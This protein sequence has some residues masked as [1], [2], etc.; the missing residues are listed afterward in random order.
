M[1]KL[2]YFLSSTLL[3][4][5]FT[6]MGPNTMGQTPSITVIQPNGGEQWVVGTSH[7]IS[8]TDNL[9]QPVMIVLTTNGVNDTLTHSVSGTTWTWDIPSTQDTS[10][11]C[12][13]KIVSTVDNSVSATSDAFF[14]L[15]GSQ[16][17]DSNEF[18]Q[19]NGGEAW[20]AG[21]SH[22]V[23][24]TN[25]VANSTLKLSIDNGATYTTLPGAD[26]ITGSTFTWDIPSSQT[27]SGTCLLK[28]QS[29]SDTNVY[30]L[31]DSLFSIVSTP[32]SGEISLFQPS[33]AGIHWKQGTEHLISWSDNFDAP[34]KIELLRSGNLY[35][36][37]S[38]S[39]TG[40]GY[41]WTVSDTLPADTSYKVV[42]LNTLNSAISDTSNYSFTIDT[43]TA[44]DTTAVAD[45][46][47]L[48]QPNG[49]DFWAVGTEHLIS[50]YDNFNSPVKIELMKAD[51]VYSVLAASVSGNGF[52]WEIADSIPVGSDFKIK[53]TSTADTAVHDVS[54][55]AFSILATPSGGVISLIQPD[56]AENWVLG[57]EHLISWSDNFTNP[58]TVELY[59]TDTLYSVLATGITD[60]RYAWTIAD[61]IPEG[62]DFMIKVFNEADTTIR[63]SSSVNFSIIAIPPNGEIK[64]AQPNGDE[65]W[66]MNH[67][68]LISW[69][70]NFSYPV[71]VDL[72]HT[73]TLYTVLNASVTGNSYTWS[74]PDTIPPDTT[75]RVRV[76][77]TADTSVWD[78]SD[79]TFTILTHLAQSINLV[80]PNGGETWAVGTKHLLSWYS[81]F[82]DPVKV[83][84]YHDDTLYAVLDSNNTDNRY[85]WNIS[86]TTLVDTGYKVKIFSMVDTTVA[87]VSDSSFSVVEFVPGGTIKLVQPND[88]AIQW[89]RGN[90]YIISWTD[91]L[92]EPVDITLLDSTASGYVA[93]PIA[94]DVPGST[95]S[96]EIP[97][98]VDLGDQ[99]KIV[100]ASSLQPIS[101]TSNNFFSIVQFQPGGTIHLVQPSDT[102]IEWTPDTKHLISWTD[103]LKEPIDIVLLREAN[104]TLDTLAKD[105]EGSTYTWHIPD[106]ISLGSYK[107]IVSSSLQAIDDTSENSFSI[108]PYVPG[109]TVHVIQP[110]VEGIYWARGTEHL[111][112]WTDN[113]KEPVNI[114]LT[115]GTDTT[116][117][118]SNVEGSTYSWDISDTTP[119]AANYRIIVASSAQPV[120]D[121]SDSTFSI[122]A[123]VPGGMIQ[124]MQP[125]RGEKWALG[126]AHLISWT[127]NLSESVNI[128]LIDT[129][130]A[131]TS[132][133]AGNVEGSTYAWTIPNTLTAGSQYKIKV[134]SSLQPISDVSDSTFSL[135]TYEPG[136]EVTVVQPNGK[137]QWTKGNAYLISWTRNFAYP[138]KVELLKADTVYS[139]LDASVDGNSMTWNIPNTLPVDN[140]YSIKVINTV[141][142]SVW[143]QSDT[144]FSIVAYTPGGFITLE[145][146]NGG[147][148]WKLGSQHLISWTNNFTEPVNVEL[149]DSVASPVYRVTIGSNVMGN[150]FTW[151]VEDTLPTSNNYRILVSNSANSAIYDESDG[152]FSLIAP[153]KISVYPNPSTNFINITLPDKGDMNYV[154]NVYNRYGTRVY[155]SVLNSINSQDLRLPT[156]N[157]PNGIY[158]VTL[159]SST[160]RTSQMFIVQH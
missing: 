59:K 104:T 144:T 150:S 99:Y 86:D 61:S 73:D 128:Y 145:Q 52:G 69:S 8:W 153:S 5:L 132:L 124:V 114:S 11:Q 91:N 127:D 76:T 131:D 32:S 142:T 15:K 49:G 25:Y 74:V 40:S 62:H 47:V 101:D 138:L 152:D 94:T 133:I 13:I 1:K 48:V 81:N 2:Y 16:P 92:G 115:D 55:S 67:D 129:V 20:A 17:A 30:I 146:P 28:L 26:S 135:T 136:G 113:L 42:V 96:W 50:W 139:V 6:M 51:T 66:A 151:T 108:V 158:F 117:L 154:V 39:E 21:T 41:A 56:S 122:V 57:T 87:D 46:I 109:G 160:E 75:Y 143:D 22:L 34:V 112:S 82:D 79:T 121:E 97:N 85:T 147:E 159:T 54:D 12:K 38:A 31:S 18:I 3:A 140:D 37:L 33:D 36:T 126:T 98:T 155:T 149:I 89:V 9:T 4:I 130:A 45:T 80:Q 72:Y 65:I 60:N 93:T 116:L 157:L 110:N 64:L 35:S 156:Y 63:D 27:L 134:A 137:E 141:D 102:G 88:T 53:L 95:Y 100:V 78:E 119:V 118:A 103:N 70:D 107:I 84:L 29:R 71:K 23:T 19:P 123:Y 43:V 83:E 24:W 106:T 148:S 68:Y 120:S 58:V 111:I 105:V 44:G 14:A 90:E 10:S 77:S 125:N 7:L